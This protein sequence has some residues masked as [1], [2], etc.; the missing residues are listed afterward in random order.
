M[1]GHEDHDSD[2]DRVGHIS[3]LSGEGV[4]AA[5]RCDRRRSSVTKVAHAET[6]DTCVRR[7]SGPAL[8]QPWLLPEPLLPV[9]IHAA[10]KADEDKL[11][12]ALQ[13]LVAE[14]VTMRSEHNVETHQLVLWALRPG[15]RR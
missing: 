12:T 9:A 5:H 11:A 2:A 14:D 7:P 1:A 3:T 10:S 8:V 15:A 13:R 6:S 4:G